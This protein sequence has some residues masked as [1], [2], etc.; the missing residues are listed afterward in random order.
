MY[1]K[2]NHCIWST[3]EKMMA[4]NSYTVTP[5]ELITEEFLTMNMSIRKPVAKSDTEDFSV[6]K[7]KIKIVFAIANMKANNFR[8]RCDFVSCI[9][10]ICLI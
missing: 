1:I 4:E 3:L 9:I 8:T 10:L 5:N 6:T 7:I 2:Y